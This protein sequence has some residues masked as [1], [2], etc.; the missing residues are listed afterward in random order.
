MIS[1]Q[2]GRFIPLPPAANV[3]KTSQ[4]LTLSFSSFFFSDFVSSTP[5]ALLLRLPSLT[6]TS[7]DFMESIL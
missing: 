2:D 5:K 3:Y 6:T 1:C 7:A 4:I